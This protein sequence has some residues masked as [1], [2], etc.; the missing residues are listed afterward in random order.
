MNGPTS[1]APASTAGSA[2]ELLELLS[3]KKRAA[4]VIAAHDAAKAGAEEARAKLAE[5]HAAL[6]K[7]MAAAL[8]HAKD[9]E[10]REAKMAKETLE[11]ARKRDGDLRELEGVRATTTAQAREMAERKVTF[12]QEWATADANQRSRTSALDERERLLTLREETVK[13]ESAVLATKREE[14]E[15]DRAALD[16]RQSNLRKLLE[17][18]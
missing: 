13:A 3:N 9:L 11:L 4:E 6:Q 10:A 8:E 14:Y 16:A 18:G 17:Q 7:E 5:Q 2:L 15:R 12:E 1:P